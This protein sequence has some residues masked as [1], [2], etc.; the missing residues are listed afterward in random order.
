[1]MIFVMCDRSYFYILLV[2]FILQHIEIHSMNMI[3]VY[4]SS[5]FVIRHPCSVT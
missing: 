1:M 5:T 2:M 3:V 4:D